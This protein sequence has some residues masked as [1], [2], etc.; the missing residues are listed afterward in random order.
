M[1]N[2]NDAAKFLLS[3]DPEHDYFNKTM[4]SHNGRSFYKGNARL[5]KMLHLAQNIYIGKTGQLL[6]DVPFYAYDNG[7]VARDIQEN[8]TMLL[9]T[10]LKNEVFI[11]ED[12]KDYLR[13]IFIIFKDTPINELVVIDHEDP[14]WLEKHSYYEI[15][16]LVMDSLKYVE[17]Y[18]HRYAD[19]NE[20]I[21]KMRV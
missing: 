20:C 14:A 16:D 21:E 10:A 18:R 13:K 12:I 4:Y 19:I 2:I 1:V 11:D 15:S 9:A 7:G 17:D 3:L 5:N 6:F 8:Y